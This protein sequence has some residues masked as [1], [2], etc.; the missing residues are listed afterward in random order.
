MT[1]Q[2]RLTILGCGSSGGVPRLSP[3]GT[4]DWGDCDPANPKNR[5]RRCSLLVE[6]INGNA[7]TRVLIDT[8][9]D[10]REQL[11]SSQIGQLDGVV[12]THSHAD[13]VHG[14]DDLRQV[15]FNIRR[16][17]PV[18]ADAPTSADL[19]ARFA[20]AFEQ[21]AGSPYPAILD[22]RPIDG[23]F[24]VD[25]P[26]GPIPFTPFT[27]NHGSIDA[28]GFRIFDTAYLPDVL[29]IPAAAWPQLHGLDLWI[30]DA[31]RRTPHPSHAHLELA[32]DWIAR[33]APRRAVLTN[34]HLDMDYDTLCAQLP[35][36]ITPAY[37]GL[38]LTLELPSTELPE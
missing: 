11:L 1:A 19:R 12:Y 8:S 31:L 6:K 25:G 38:A 26:A 9:P 30:L 16:R 17:L 3:D 2:L 14:L 22:L 24:E 29:D 13:H 5:R 34:M 23:P 7:V 15:V 4:G 18:W 20:Y 10:M 21:E 32:L 35:P 37:D 28:L 36:N 33:A 27:V